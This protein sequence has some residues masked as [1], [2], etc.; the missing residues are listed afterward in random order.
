MTTWWFSK[1]SAPGY[2]VKSSLGRETYEQNSELHVHLAS[3]SGNQHPVDHHCRLSQYVIVSAF[4]ECV[5]CARV[6]SPII[7]SCRAFDSGHFF[8]A[9]INPGDDLI[10]IE[11]SCSG[12]NAEIE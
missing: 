12:E 9:R 1:T 5:V 3:A 8:S 7:D 4:P 6:V 11:N 10:E 2:V